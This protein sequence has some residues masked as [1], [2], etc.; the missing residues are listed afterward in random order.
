MPSKRENDRRRAPKTRPAASPDDFPP[1]SIS[2]RV[3]LQ[4]G[5]DTAFRKLIY[6]LLSLSSLLLRSRDRFAAYIGVSGPQYS[7]MMVVAE[8]GAATI[9]QIADALRV[10][11][12]FVT[13]EVGKLERRE[14]V[15]KR[16]NAAD[17]RSNLIVLTDL[18]RGLILDL[19]PLRREVNDMIYGSLDRAQVEQLVAIVDVLHTDAARALHVLDSP[20]YRG[21]VAPSAKDANG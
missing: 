20:E 12:P 4:D 21:K 7:M 10:S 18:G 14:L 15:E 5:S 13:A 1:L 2:S 8:A 9:G 3:W 16:R 11:S 19:A 17:A 6:E